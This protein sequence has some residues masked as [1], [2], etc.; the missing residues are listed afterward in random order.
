M[1]HQESQLLW[2]SEGDTLTCFFHAHENNC[3]R[4]NHIYSLIHEGRVLVA[5]ADKAEVAFNFYDLLLGKLAS[6]KSTCVSYA[7]VSQKMRYEQL[8]GNFP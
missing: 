2:L 5:E 1:A 6:R 7:P 3:R 4:K 8:L